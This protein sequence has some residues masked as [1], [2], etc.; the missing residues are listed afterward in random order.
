MAVSPSSALGRGCP[1]LMCCS[2]GWVG[3]AG[4][5]R[6]GSRGIGDPEDGQDL[7]CI[8]CT[9]CPVGHSHLW[10]KAIAIRAIFSL[11]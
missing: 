7:S 3:A 10:T 1:V 4:W 5:A 11:N 2:T 6:R 9:L 8:S